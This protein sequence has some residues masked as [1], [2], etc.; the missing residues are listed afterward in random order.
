VFRA[1]LSDEKD[2]EQECDDA[3]NNANNYLFDCQHNGR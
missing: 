2:G 3:D 1:D